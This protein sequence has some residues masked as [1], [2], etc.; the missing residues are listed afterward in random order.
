MSQQLQADYTFTGA[1]AASINAIFL[2][3]A[4]MALVVDMASGL[5]ELR[6]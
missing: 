4:D 3:H 1:L 6:I 2:M 5:C